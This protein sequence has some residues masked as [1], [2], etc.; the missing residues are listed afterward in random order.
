MDTDKSMS[1]KMLKNVIFQLLGQ[2]MKI[3]NFFHSLSFNFSDYR[4]NGLHLSIVDSKE[5]YYNLGII[6]KTGRTGPRM[7]QMTY[8]PCN[9]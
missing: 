6:R 5:K 8:H 2:K 1:N 9:A 3:C 4:N 7:M